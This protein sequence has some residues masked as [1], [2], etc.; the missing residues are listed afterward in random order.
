MVRDARRPGGRGGEGGA[1]RAI[2]SPG[3]ATFVREAAAVRVISLGGE[4]VRCDWG[5]EDMFINVWVWALA[6]CQLLYVSRA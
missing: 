5:N 6:S 4:G 3:M 2:P 1:W